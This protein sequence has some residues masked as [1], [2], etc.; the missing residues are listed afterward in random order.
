M[1]THTFFAIVLTTVIFICVLFNRYHQ[2][3][4]CSVMWFHKPQCGWCRKMEVEW[5]RFTAMIPKTI[6]A[7]KIDTSKQENFD[8]ARKFK[9]QTVP[10][11]VKVKNNKMSVFKGD[12][13]AENFLFWASS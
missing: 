13:T 1:K 3:F 12:R 9:V 11:I 10:H 6:H 5:D 4:H 8:L 7:K 2:P